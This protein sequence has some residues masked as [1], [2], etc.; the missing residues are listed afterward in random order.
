MYFRKPMSFSTCSQ[1]M[2]KMIIK[3]KAGDLWNRYNNKGT[4]LTLCKRNKWLFEKINRI[5]KP[6][7]K[8]NWREKFQVN[9]TWTPKNKIKTCTDKTLRI[10]NQCL[11]FLICWLFFKFLTIFILF[12]NNFV[13]CFSL[14]RKW[15]GCNSSWVSI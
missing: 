6:T 12:L 11:C 3:S 10:I 14:S 1:R 8:L 4:L 5:D 9:K 15:R 13:N 7:T 2:W